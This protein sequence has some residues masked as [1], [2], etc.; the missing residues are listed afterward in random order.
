MVQDDHCHRR[1]RRIE[2]ETAYKCTSIFLNAGHILLSTFFKKCVV[3]KEKQNKRTSLG[4]RG[5][6]VLLATISS[7]SSELFLYFS[8]NKQTTSLSFM[9]YFLLHML[10]WWMYLCKVYHALMQSK[11][12]VICCLGD[13]FFRLLFFSFILTHDHTTWQCSG[14]G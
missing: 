6:F 7:N 8:Q 3:M 1:N 5:R 4:L 14:S 13:G 2:G 9:L 12:V 11:R 10:L